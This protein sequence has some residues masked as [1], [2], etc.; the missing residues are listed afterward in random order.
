M[1]EEK[2]KRSLADTHPEIAKEANGWD[3]SLIAPK[4]DKKLQW[5]CDLGHSFEA[6]VA[7]RTNL[8]SGCPYCSGNKVLPGFNDLLTRFPD[9]AREAD[10]WDP[11]TV[12]PGTGKAHPWICENGHRWVVAPNQRTTRN[13]TGC[14]FC[15]HNQVL[16]GVND[17][18]TLFPKIAREADGWDPRQVAAK[19]GQKKNWVCVIGHRW[20]ATPADRSR[21][22]G[23]P[24]CGGKRVLAGFNDLSTTHPDLASEAFD[25][26]P[27]TV[28]FGSNKSRKWMCG[29]GHTWN[30]TPNTRTNNSSGCPYCSNRYV[31]AG[32]N[33]LAT[34]H[35]DV[36]CEAYGWDPST[37]LPGSNRRVKW[38]CRVDHIWTVSP[39]SRT[40]KGGTGCPTCAPIG[41]DPN[42]DAWLYSLDHEEWGLL[43]IGITND[44]ETRISKHK[45]L[46]WDVVELRGPMDGHLVQDWETAILRHIKKQ[47]GK[48]AD[49]IGIEPFDGYSESWLKESFSFGS[50]KEIMEKVD[51]RPE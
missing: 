25:W 33:D 19:S 39:G 4:S 38:K 5:K 31:L 35:P 16:P 44:P 15:S 20:N 23:C 36:A 24:Y 14:P 32:F 41:F 28:N 17:L 49:K 27:R 47:G 50:F 12:T 34:T 48:F 22:D 3:P 30:A 46:G 1:P 51:E 29:L 6:R 42:K 7:N 11:S 13:G 2:K 26:D 21:G 10:G 8:G 43:Q 45:R 9:I 37:L 40:G 18:Q